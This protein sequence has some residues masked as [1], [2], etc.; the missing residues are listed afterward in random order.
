MDIGKYCYENYLQIRM[1]RTI[2]FLRHLAHLSSSLLL[3]ITTLPWIGIHSV[4][5]TP[6]TGTHYFDWKSKSIM[7]QIIKLEGHRSRGQM[8][9]RA[10]INAHFQVMLRSFHPPTP[11]LACIQ[12]LCSKSRLDMWGPLR[13]MPIMGDGKVYHEVVQ[14]MGNIWSL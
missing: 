11:W 10:D 7:L 14:G 1:V 4:F 8:M 3:M 13:C 2:L 9:L 6:L 5:Y 12:M